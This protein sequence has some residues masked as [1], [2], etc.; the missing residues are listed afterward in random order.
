MRKA[1]SQSVWPDRDREAWFSLGEKH[2]KA[3][4]FPDSRRRNTGREPRFRSS[5]KIYRKSGFGLHQLRNCW[6]HWADAAVG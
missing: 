3:H 1:I 6:S 2:E 5:N 4:R